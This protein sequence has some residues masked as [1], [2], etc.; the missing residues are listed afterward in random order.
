MFRGSFSWVISV[1]ALLLPCISVGAGGK[2]D[3]SYP[4]LLVTPRA[5][6]RL[7]IESKNESSRNLSSQFPFLVSG[8]I[9]LTSGLLQ[10]SGKDPNR[11]RQG[12]TPIIGVGVGAA[13][14][15]G[16][17]LLSGY[18]PYTRA[19]EQISP[20]PG[21]TDREQLIRERYAEEAIER[22]SGLGQ[23][24]KWISFATNLLACAAITGSAQS[25]ALSKPMAGVGVATAFLP[26]LFPPQWIDVADQ[27]REYKKKIYGPVASAGFLGGTSSVAPVPGL[28]LSFSF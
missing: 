10:F 2:D 22:A 7:D 27:Q 1:I 26:L 9:T 15:V 4:E 16:G 19:V 13:W 23:R 28:L 17:F 20:M 18:R 5:S 3:F 8:A 21:K 11:D 6:Q 12:S 24:L 25:D 14:L